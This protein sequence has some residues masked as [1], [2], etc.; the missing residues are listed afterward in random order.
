MPSSPATRRKPRASSPSVTP[1]YPPASSTLTRLPRTQLEAAAN[2]SSSPASMGCPRNSASS[3]AIS[4]S[5]ARRNSMRTGSRG[6]FLPLSRRRE[7]ARASNSAGKLCVVHIDANAD[8]GVTQHRW[9][10]RLRGDGGGLH[11]DA[12]TLF[13][14][15]QKIVGPAN[16]RR[17]SLSRWRWLPARRGRSQERAITRR[18]GPS[19]GAAAR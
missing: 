8:Y 3:N 1:V 18:P 19:G 16:I 14:A 4:L 13:V 12:A 9:C 2:R 10:V 7:V 17:E 15:D 11:Q 5:R 6:H